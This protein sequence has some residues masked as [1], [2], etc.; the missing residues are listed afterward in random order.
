LG[1]ANA[2]LAVPPNAFTAGQNAKVLVTGL[3]KNTL[4]SAPRWTR[5][6]LNELSNPAKAASI[7]SFYGKQP[8]F[9]SGTGLS[10]TGRNP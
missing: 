4:A 10:P 5:N 2:L 7:Y 8:Y 3:D 9:Q 1:N 6:N